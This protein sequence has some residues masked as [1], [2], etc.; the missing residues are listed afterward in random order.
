MGD[1]GNVI[2]GYGG[3]W[4]LEKENRDAINSVQIGKSAYEGLEFIRR[5]GVTNML[6]RSMVLSLAKEWDL[7]ATVDWIEGVDTGTYGRLILRGPD[8]IGDESLDEKL[9]RMDRAYDKERK[10][11]WEG[12][13]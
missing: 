7:D 2:I 3:R 12:T 10:G 4:E 8:V 1:Y 11:F 9:D 6:D 13:E 5:S